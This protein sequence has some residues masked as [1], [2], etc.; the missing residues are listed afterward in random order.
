MTADDGPVYAPDLTGR[1]VDLTGRKIDDILRATRA[2][3][4]AVNA[5]AVKNA[6]TILGSQWY[7]H[8]PPEDRAALAL[9][10]IRGTIA[11]GAR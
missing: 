10:A 5:K 4:D 2:D 1:T 6:R 8:F 11:G 3:A 9:S 7:D